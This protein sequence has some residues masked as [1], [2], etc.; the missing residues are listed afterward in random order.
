M[1][2]KMQKLVEI[3]QD[4]LALGNPPLENNY[5]IVEKIYLSYKLME[6]FSLAIFAKRNNRKWISLSR[7]VE[8]QKPNK[9]V[10]YI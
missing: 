1:K 6:Y 9:K 4:F 7:G 8:S 2:N 3:W 5:Q 10:A